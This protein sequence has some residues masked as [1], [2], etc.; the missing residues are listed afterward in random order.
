VLVLEVEGEVVLLDKLY[1]LPEYK[2]VL[3]EVV[4]QLLGDFFLPLH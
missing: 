4:V 1:P 3:E 2:G